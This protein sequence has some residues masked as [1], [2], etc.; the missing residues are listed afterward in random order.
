MEPPPA[1][2]CTPEALLA[3]LQALGIESQTVYHPAA[4]TC[5]EHAKHVG[6]LGGGQAKQLFL[7]GKEG[8]FY[9]V[10]CLVDTVVDLKRA[11]A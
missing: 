10:S 6:H 5:E 3:K 2:A 1:E 7:R 9:L 4:P 8:A 11:Q